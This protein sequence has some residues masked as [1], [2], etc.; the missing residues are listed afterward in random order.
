MKKVGGKGAQRGK[1]NGIVSSGRE[2]AMG[3]TSEVSCAKIGKRRRKSLND[4]CYL[5]NQGWYKSAANGGL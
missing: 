5:S 1:E 4:I 2:K 3:K